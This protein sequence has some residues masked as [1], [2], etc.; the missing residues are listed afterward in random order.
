MKKLSQNMYNFD[1][2]LEHLPLHFSIPL[3]QLKSYNK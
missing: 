1:Y 2:D 3:T